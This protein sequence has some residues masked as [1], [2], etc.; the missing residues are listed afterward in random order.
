MT[1][2]NQNMFINVLRATLSLMQTENALVEYY[3]VVEDVQANIE[4]ILNTVMSLATR[5][6]E[7]KIKYLI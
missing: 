3:S 1:D 2:T 5:R 6:Y 4:H 7:Q